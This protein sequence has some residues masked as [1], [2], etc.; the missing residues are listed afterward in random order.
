[1]QARYDVT[2]DMT[3]LGKIIGGGFPFGA[4]AGR[5]EVMD[6]LNPQ[7]PRACSPTPEHSRPT[8]SKHLTAGMAAM[9]KFDRPAVGAPKRA[10]RSGQ[11]RHRRR[12]PRDGRAREA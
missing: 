7:S 10:D 4:V 11:E 8:R 2:P 9:L 6:V 5:A 1:M 12:D 3:A